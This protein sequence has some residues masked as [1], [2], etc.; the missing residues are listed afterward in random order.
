MDSVDETD[1]DPAVIAAEAA[2][3][4]ANDA[5]TLAKKTLETVTKTVE[6]KKA[7][8]VSISIDPD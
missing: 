8:E 1:Q 3:T 4:T 6:K 5:L 2:W 7:D